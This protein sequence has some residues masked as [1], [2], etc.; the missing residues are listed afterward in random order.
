MIRNAN[1]VICFDGEC[2]L[3]NKFIGFVMKNNIK[4][5]IYFI[6]SQSQNVKYYFKSIIMT[7]TNNAIFYKKGDNI[8]S[9]SKAAIAILNDLDGIYP[10]ISS[11]L[12]FIPNKILDR[13]YDLIAKNRYKIYSKETFCSKNRYVR[14]SNYIL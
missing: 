5:D 8:Y 14:K 1:K 7:Q 4:G 6:S 12:T 9:K 11:L 3:C 2:S 13:F 10:Y